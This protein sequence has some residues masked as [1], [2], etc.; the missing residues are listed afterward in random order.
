MFVRALLYSIGVAVAIVT[1]G[2]EPAVLP[3]DPKE[4]MLAALRLNNLTTPDAKPWHIKATFQLFD[5]Q[6]TIT[7]EGTYEE[8]W[9]SPVK[10][11]RIFIGK[12]FSQTEYG[13]PGGAL[14]SDEHGDTP[15]LMLEARNNLVNPMPGE[16]IINNTTYKTK[17]MDAGSV[18]VICVIPTAI[19]PGAPADTST[20]CF[21]MDEPVL[22]IASRPSTSDE[23]LHN[24]F[25]RVEGRAIAGD[26]KIMHSGK[27]RVEFKVD[28]ATALDASDDAAFTP[29]PSAVRAPLKIT[30]SGGVAAASL[31]Y[32]VAPEYPSAARNAH[33]TG[34]VVLRG[35]IGK[36]GH[37]KNL[38]ALSGPQALQGAAM[39]AVQQWRYQP[40]LLNGQAVEVQTTINV[41]FQLP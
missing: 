22:R 16:T 8:S 40:Y 2:Q 35:V 29:P 25:L 18:K 17:T 21:D 36:D 39:Q 38:T 11:K 9:A 5:E 7:D 4:L 3:S 13:S 23:S 26:L 31:K 6:G 30:I 24:R 33:I 37:V 34:T 27:V 28:S 32:R 1:Q 12:D 19:T 10:F 20:H 14:A 41:V 15:E